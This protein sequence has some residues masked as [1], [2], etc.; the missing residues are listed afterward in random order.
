MYGTFTSNALDGLKRV[1]CASILVRLARHKTPGLLDGLEVSSLP[2]ILPTPVYGESV[3][4]STRCKPTP[5]ERKLYHFVQQNKRRITVREALAEMPDFL[6]DPKQSD[7]ELHTLIDT[8]LSKTAGVVPMLELDHIVKYEEKFGFKV[9]V[10]GA[11]NLPKPGYT[12]AVMSLVPPGVLYGGKSIKKMDDVL[13]TKQIDFASSLRSPIWFDG[14]QW[15]RRKIMDPRLHVVVEL[16]TLESQIN[17]VKTTAPGWTLCRIFS[18]SGYVKSD[19][20]MLPLIEGAPTK[21][22]LEQFMKQVSTNTI[23]SPFET[24]FADLVSRKVIKL[25][26]G[27]SVF[28]RTVDARRDDEFVFDHDKTN[29]IYIPEKLKNGYL[30]SK[31]GKQVRTLAGDED[32]SDWQRRLVNVF[33]EEA[34]F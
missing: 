24:V 23:N 20:F 17:G 7:A 10:D 21:E 19:L 30:D 12:I 5:T 33:K 25:V 15:F 1:P 26:K 28:L 18:D 13:Y 27:A 11:Q 9:S 29:M 34:K 14:F 3:Y 8:K 16:K 31:S 22:I 4:D 6:K 2:V 32:E